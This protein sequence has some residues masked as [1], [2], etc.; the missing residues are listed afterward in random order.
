M[1]FV[2]YLVVPAGTLAANYVALIFSISPGIIQRCRITFPAGC[3]RMVNVFSGVLGSPVFPGTV[4]SYYA[5]DNHTVE[6]DDIYICDVPT[7]FYFCGYAPKTSYS[8]SIGIKFDLLTA[9]EL[10]MKRSGYY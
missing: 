7:D 2:G 5:E 4:G 10:S 9:E 6:I 1:Q 3:S 8:H